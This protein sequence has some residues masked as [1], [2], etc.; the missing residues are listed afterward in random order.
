MYELTAFLCGHFHRDKDVAPGQLS[1]ELWSV[2][3]FDDAEAVALK[4]M[5][6]AEFIDFFSDS[7]T[8]MRKKVDVKHQLP[9]RDSMY[10]YNVDEITVFQMPL[11]MTLF[12]VGIRMDVNDLN[13]VTAVLSSLR[14]IDNYKDEIHK[15]FIE[16]VLMPVKRI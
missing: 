7:C 5:F 15:P 8:I 10:S 11:G 16:A 3:T 6:Y 13:D 2:V 9:F 14:M 12:S 1:Q 4:R